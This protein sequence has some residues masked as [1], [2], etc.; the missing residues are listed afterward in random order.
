VRVGFSA[1]VVG[2]MFAAARISEGRR[3]EG[4]RGRS[5]LCA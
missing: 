1:C 2:E 4:E 3:A 5:T